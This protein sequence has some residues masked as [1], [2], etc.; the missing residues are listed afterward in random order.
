MISD[1]GDVVHQEYAG[2]TNDRYQQPVWVDVWRVSLDH[3]L[4]DAALQ[5]P[6][7]LA[8]R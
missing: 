1:D 7:Q 8:W 6:K 3:L 5:V 2:V 4:A